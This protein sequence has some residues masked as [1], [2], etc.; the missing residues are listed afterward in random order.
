MYVQH[1]LEV[2]YIHTYILCNMMNI[3]KSY[4]L[5]FVLH[6]TNRYTYVY[7]H[8][9][10]YLHT[11]VGNTS[12]ASLYTHISIKFNFDKSDGNIWIRIDLDGFGG[13]SLAGPN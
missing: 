2:M 12:F 10:M 9:L 3:S 13:D 6:F 4:E 7:L 5:I 11:Y 8:T 1:K